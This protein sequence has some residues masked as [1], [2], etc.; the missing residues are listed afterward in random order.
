MTYRSPF[1]SVKYRAKLDVRQLP[2]ATATRHRGEPGQR[3]AAAMAAARV[4][5]PPRNARVEDDKAKSVGLC[6]GTF[7]LR[8]G[9]SAAFQKGMPALYTVQAQRDLHRLAP[10]HMLQ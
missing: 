3:H 5:Q 4:T 1:V 10:L 6:Q 2:C 8:V 9:G 7:Y